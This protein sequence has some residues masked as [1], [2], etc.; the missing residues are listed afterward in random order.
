MVVFIFLVC[1][2]FIG[3]S[4]LVLFLL[5]AKE[6]KGTGDSNKMVHAYS[7]T[8][9]S[10]LLSP[11]NRGVDD[12]PRKPVASFQIGV[13]CQGHQEQESP[14]RVGVYDLTITES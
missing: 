13:S 5:K 4:D 9:S 14:V 6:K 3:E 10:T 2:H 12:M 8:D 7:I 11:A 1:G